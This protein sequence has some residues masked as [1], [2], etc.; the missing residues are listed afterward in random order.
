MASFMGIFDNPTLENDEH[1]KQ[2]VYNAQ[3]KIFK[4]MLALAII[5]IPLSIILHLLAAA[6]CIGIISSV[7][8]CVFLMLSGDSPWNEK[9]RARVYINDKQQKRKR[10]LYAILALLFVSIVWL[11]FDL[12]M[13]LQTLGPYYFM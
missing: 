1:V 7:G 2:K 4:F 6:I 9:I 11:I 13:G 12:V 3:Y 5:A 10:L 8:I